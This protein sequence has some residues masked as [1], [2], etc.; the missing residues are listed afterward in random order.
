D[1]SLEDATGLSLRHLHKFFSFAAPPPDVRKVFDLP[2]A[3]FFYGAM[4]PAFVFGKDRFARAA[5]SGL[6][7]SGPAQN[8][9]GVAPGN[10]SQLP[11]G[12]RPISAEIISYV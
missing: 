3:R 8:V 2:K 7:R 9:G 11:E 4:P 10:K 5:I 1:G 12:R 6:F